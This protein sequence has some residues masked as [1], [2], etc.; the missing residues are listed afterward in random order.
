[1]KFEVCKEGN[2]VAQMG[3]LQITVTLYE[4]HNGNFSCIL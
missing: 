3:C 2:V 1:M 4:R